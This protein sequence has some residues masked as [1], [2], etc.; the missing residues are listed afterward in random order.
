M[1]IIGLIGVWALLLTLISLGTFKIEERKTRTRNN[2]LL[3]SLPTSLDALDEQ[4]AQLN[5]KAWQAYKKSLF[6]LVGSFG[7][8]GVLTFFTVNEYEKWLLFVLVFLSIMI[9]AAWLHGMW[10][11][12]RYKGARRGIQLH[13]QHE[14][15]E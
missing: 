1:P 8:T 4:L 7:L 15:A 9:S 10:H 12:G 11:Y 2:A 14:Q 5:V 13:V 3:R 6:Y